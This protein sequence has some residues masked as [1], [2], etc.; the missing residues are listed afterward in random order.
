MKKNLLFLCICFLFLTAVTCFR[1]RDQIFLT[2][3][4]LEKCK[5]TVVLDPGHGGDDPGKV[6]INNVLEKDINLAIALKC[7]DILKKQNIKVILTRSSDN[8]L[9]H[10]S[11]TNKKAS[12]LKARRTMIE[13]SDAD[14][15]VSIHQNS[16]PAENVFGG[17]VFYYT[18]SEQGKQLAGFLQESIRELNPE[19]KRVTK[20]NTDYYILKSGV[21]PVVI[22]ECG[23]L[24]NEKE[25]ASLNSLPYQKEMANAIAKGIL[26]Y[27]YAMH[28]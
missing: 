14:L 25:C 2:A 10:S 22:C 28:K 19:N 16:Y 4:K 21:C 6:G 12:D 20:A 15:A 13:T 3:V 7:K 27:L 18:G 17:Q 5:Y 8:G 24:S 11:D 26:S 9:Y 1:Q 23:F